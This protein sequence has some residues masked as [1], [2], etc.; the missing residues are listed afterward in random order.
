MLILIILNWPKIGYTGIREENAY[1]AG[2]TGQ[3]GRIRRNGRWE[4]AMMFQ[5]S[6]GGKPLGS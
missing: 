1:I 3:G 4:K 6:S 5:V 2:I